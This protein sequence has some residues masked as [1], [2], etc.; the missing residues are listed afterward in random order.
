MTETVAFSSPADEKLALELVAKRTK[1]LKTRSAELEQMLREYG[2]HK[3]WCK[4]WDR[5]SDNSCNCGWE[6]ARKAMEPRK[7]RGEL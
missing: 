4:W 5:D 7:E 6:E 1:A 3:R 2:H